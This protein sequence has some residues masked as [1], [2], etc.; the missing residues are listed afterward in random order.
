MENNIFEEV[1]RNNIVAV[2]QALGI[3]P[4]LPY[5][6][7][8]EEVRAHW[9]A[10]VAVLYKKQRKA[11]ERAIAFTEEWRYRY[12]PP[13]VRRKT[14]RLWDKSIKLFLKFMHEEFSWW[15]EVTRDHEER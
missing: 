12:S 13:D 5:D 4:N 1:V 10:H 15:E 2:A 6:Q 14:N 9:P 7:L 11:H 8:E 3:D